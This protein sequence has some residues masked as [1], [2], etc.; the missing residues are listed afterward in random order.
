MG[1]TGRL[2]YRHLR[3]TVIAAPAA[4][5]V[6]LLLVLLLWLTW[7]GHR[8]ANL[9][10]MLLLVFALGWLLVAEASTVQKSVAHKAPFG[11]QPS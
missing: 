1:R 3:R 6:F 11:P 5:A 10:P 8:R 9:F 2:R 4:L 7:S